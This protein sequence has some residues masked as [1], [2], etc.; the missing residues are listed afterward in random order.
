M[1]KQG[2]D[3]MDVMD[4]LHTARR[5]SRQLD[6][7]WRTSYPRLEERL[8]EELSGIESKSMMTCHAR[9]QLTQDTGSRTH[10]PLNKTYRIT[11]F[12]APPGPRTKTGSSK[13]TIQSLKRRPS[14]AKAKVCLFLL[15]LLS[16]F[17]QI[18]P[19]FSAPASPQDGSPFLLSV[20]A[21]K[22]FYR[23]ARTSTPSQLRRR[24][25]AKTLS[26]TAHSAGAHKEL[27]AFA[28]SV[29]WEI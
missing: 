28:G 5:I 26:T 11:L 10:C 23:P 19:S 1:H 15:L 4:L 22:T 6:C 18:P 29:Y 3:S 25:R 17:S 7:P 13:C 9:L 24:L 2:A 27:K 12:K 8:R 16:T 20:N 21:G 14:Q